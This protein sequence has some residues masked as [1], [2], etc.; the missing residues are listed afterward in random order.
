MHQTLIDLEES[1]SPQEKFMMQLLIRQSAKEAFVHVDSCQKIRKA[2]L[3]KSV[4]QRGPYRVGNLINFY[5][6]GK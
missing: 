1:K 5:R 4:P 2:L 3:R 6:K